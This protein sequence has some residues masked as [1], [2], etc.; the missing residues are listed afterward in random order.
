ML[1]GEIPR[2][3][4]C[5]E[6]REILNL[7]NR[8]CNC[9]MAI[10][11]IYNIV[12]KLQDPSL[13]FCL[14][15]KCLIEHCFEIVYQ[16]QEKEMSRFYRSMKRFCRTVSIMINAIMPILPLTI[17]LSYIWDFL[18]IAGIWLSETMSGWKSLR[19]PGKSGRISTHVG[20]VDFG[21]FHFN[22]IQL[23]SLGLQ[24]LNCQ[25]VDINGVLSFF[26]YR[27][28]SSLNSLQ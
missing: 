17:G 21:K 19:C 25:Y 4:E 24:C 16:M 1:L 7:P 13:P 6:G 26:V 20:S 28:L 5:Q 27:L 2:V 11:A 10:L 14:K 8:M 15:L 12:N 9:S 3:V 23:P 18:D 22:P